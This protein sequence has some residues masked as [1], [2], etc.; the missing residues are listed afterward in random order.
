MSRIPIEIDGVYYP[1]RAAAC[2]QFNIPVKL[3]ESRL[4]SGRSVKQA[5]G[6]D[7]CLR[8]SQ[9]WSLTGIKN[10]N[11]TIGRGCYKLYE[12][13]NLINHKTY[14]GITIQSLRRRYKHHT[15]S[16]L[17]K[18]KHPLYNAMRKYGVENFT[19]NL[20]RADAKQGIELQEQEIAEIARRNST[21]R[22][23][24]YNLHTGG[25]AFSDNKKCIQIG[26]M[27]FSSYCEAAH[28]YNVDPK[29]FSTRLSRLG[30]TPE[31]AAEL[32]PSPTIQ[33][34][35][36]VVDGQTINLRQVARD[37]NMSPVQVRQRMRYGWT[38]REAMGID[39]Q[40][41]NKHLPKPVEVNGISFP[42]LKA[43]ADYYGMNYKTVCGRISSKQYTIREALE[44]RIDVGARRKSEVTIAFGQTYPS[45]TKC[46]KA[47]NVNPAT[48][49]HRMTHFGET[50]DEAISHL[51][52]KRNK[53]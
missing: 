9:S 33:K 27:T 16:A 29:T 47:N 1:S 2:K 26:L 28:Y 46:A 12:V 52:D 10:P 39:P 7:P 25:F 51:K 13:V 53:I 38:Y 23:K 40:P 30:W 31:Q 20:I 34:H 4:K 41:I 35:Y 22:S 36:L 5:L 49:W 3:F 11:E 32:E 45:I 6:L 17:A 19:I 37:H 15:Y 43:A 44:T 42:T 50:P 21:D 48:L 14:V 18:I 24:G 8:R